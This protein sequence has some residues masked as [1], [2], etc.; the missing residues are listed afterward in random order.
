MLGPRR[1][2]PG[3]EAFNLYERYKVS[4]TVGEAR[5][6]SAGDA[7]PTNDLKACAIAIRASTPHLCLTLPPL[8]HRRHSIGR[9]RDFY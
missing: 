9:I 8:A 1:M 4:R 2:I 7:E 3:L 5:E 6:K